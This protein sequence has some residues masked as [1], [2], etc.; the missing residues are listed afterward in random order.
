MSPF[1]ALTRAKSPLSAC[2]SMYSHVWEQ[3]SRARGWRKCSERR[4]AELAATVREP[5]SAYRVGMPPCCTS[6][7]APVRVKKAGMPRAR[8]THPFGQRAHRHKLNDHLAV[9]VLLLEDL[10]LTDV[11][12]PPSS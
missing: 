10:V 5:S 6:V 4:G 11:R 9:Q 7:P 1:H 2:S 3:S 8:C 12:P